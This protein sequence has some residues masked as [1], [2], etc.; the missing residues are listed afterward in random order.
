[1][2]PPPRPPKPHPTTYRIQVQGCVDAPWSDWFN[3]LTLAVDSD[4]EPEP[5]TTL[6][7][8]VP[9]QAALRGVLNQLWD[10]NLTLISVAQIAATS[11]EEARHDR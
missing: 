4:A 11:E 6:I 9:D 8:P 3:G 7:G 5:C 1:M 2:T 10:L